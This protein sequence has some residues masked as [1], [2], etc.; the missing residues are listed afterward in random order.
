MGTLNQPPKLTAVRT[1][2]LPYPEA[3]SFLHFYVYCLCPHD[4]F[5]PSYSFME[6]SRHILQPTY[7]KKKKKNYLQVSFHAFLPSPTQVNSLTHH[8]LQ[9]SYPVFVL[10]HCYPLLLTLLFYFL[11]IS[12]LSLLATCFSSSVLFLFPLLYQF[13]IK[14]S[15]SV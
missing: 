5:P 3:F 13:V 14:L 7:I 9:L 2:L 6:Q 10:I 12:P 8:F 11:T 1:Q 15:L 4:I